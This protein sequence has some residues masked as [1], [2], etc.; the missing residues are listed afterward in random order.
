M[1]DAIFVRLKYKLQYANFR[2]GISLDRAHFYF[3]Y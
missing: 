1:F 3:Y 2:S